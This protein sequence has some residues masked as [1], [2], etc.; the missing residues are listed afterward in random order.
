VYFGDGAISEGDVSEAFGFAASYAVPVVFFCQNNQW[1]ISEPVRLQ[2]HTS[3][4]QRGQGY[5]IPGIQVDGNDVLAVLAATRLALARAYAGQGPTLVEAVTYRMGPHTT[6]DDPTRYRSRTEEEQ[7]RAKDPLV[8]LR[9]LL[10]NEG[11]TDERV[12]AS[13]S[14]AADEAAT[15]L[16]SGCLA[17]ADPEPETLFDHVYADP[18]PLLDAER[19]AYLSYLADLEDPS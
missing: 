7:W 8:R 13:V 19:E 11:A 9:R 10:E 12:E 18:H 16:R 17:M 5:G 1:A 2:S 15:A 6:S 4:A 3:I 14:T